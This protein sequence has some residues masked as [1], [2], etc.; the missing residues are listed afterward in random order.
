MFELLLNGF[1]RSVI[2]DKYDTVE[3]N[4]E[5]TIDGASKNYTRSSSHGLFDF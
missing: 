1:G 2:V 3:Q 5:L 4:I